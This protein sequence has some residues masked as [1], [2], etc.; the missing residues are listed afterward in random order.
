M[1]IPY[2]QLNVLLSK[3]KSE[4]KF[5]LGGSLETFVRPYY[6]FCFYFSRKERLS[7]SIL[8]S[9]T[10]RYV[11]WYQAH[12][13]DYNE[14]FEVLTGHLQLIFV[15]LKSYTQKQKNAFRFVFSF[16]DSV[17]TRFDRESNLGRTITL[18]LVCLNRLAIEACEAQTFFVSFLF[19]FSQNGQNRSWMI[20]LC[21]SI[22][23]RLGLLLAQVG[24]SVPVFDVCFWTFCS[25]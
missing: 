25:D 22:R 24:S 14:G 2:L 13:A 17:K 20:F 5:H 15:H 6:T 11:L 10:F 3:E 8:C 12:W 9:K 23:Y 1:Q 21:I 7:I 18:L 4:N 19:L 16:I